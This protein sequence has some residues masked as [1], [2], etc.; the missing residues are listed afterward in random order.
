MV[1]QITLGDL[2]VDVVFKDIKNVH[3]SV[4]PPTGRVRVSAPKR[5]KLETIRAFA[6]TKISWIKRHQGKQTAQERETPR[7]YIER[8]SHYLWGRRYLMRIQESQSDF[9]LSVDHKRM[10][11]K[12]QSEWDGKKRQEIMEQW[13]RE[14]AKRKALL[15]VQ[16]WEPLLD[17]NVNKLFVQRMRTKWGSA[18]PIRRNIRLNTEL[19]RKPIDCLDYIVLHEMAHFLV[20]NHGERFLKIINEH[21]PHWKSVRDQL[22]AAPLSHLN[23][24]Y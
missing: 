18:N 3:L 10:T 24:S 9:G 7:E 6:S 15:L 11:F 1:E 23:W 8:E 21:M 19:A 16:K 14:Q 22:N 5:M 13:Y 17:V 2:T 20:P 4:Y 12:V